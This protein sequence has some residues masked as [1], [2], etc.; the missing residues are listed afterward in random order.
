MMSLHVGLRRDRRLAGI[1]G[2]SGALASPGS[3]IAEM[4]SKPPV[5]LIHGAMDNVIPFPAIFEATGA[6]EAAGIKVEKHISQ[7][8]A[9]GI[10]PD[11]MEKGL[12]FLKEVLG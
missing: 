5:F 8:V 10:A 12:N 4:K 3:L 1:L 11:G 2:Y 7:N 6:L 9:H